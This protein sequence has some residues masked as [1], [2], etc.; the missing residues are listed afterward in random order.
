MREKG[1]VQDGRGSLLRVI[2]GG[3]AGWM[4]KSGEE[5]GGVRTGW[6]G[7]WGEGEKRAQGWMDGGVG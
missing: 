2:G 1:A 6:M 4:K 5:R 3:R 7:E